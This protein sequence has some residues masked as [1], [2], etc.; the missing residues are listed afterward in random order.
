MFCHNR[1]N[2]RCLPGPHEEEVELEVDPSG[3]VG[4]QDLVAHLL[5]MVG[6]NMMSMGNVNSEWSLSHI[7][8]SAQF[9]I[10][11]SF[12][13]F[14]TFF[15]MTPGCRQMHIVP[16]TSLTGK[17]SISYVRDSIVCTWNHCAINKKQERFSKNFW[18]LIFYFNSTTL[19]SINFLWFLTPS[20]NLNG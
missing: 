15:E 8:L 17:V 19:Y 4:T 13:F 12:N 11:S 16:T 2:W 7:S 20:H 3:A 14:M 10:K 1:Y 5:K 18:R 6:M 9:T